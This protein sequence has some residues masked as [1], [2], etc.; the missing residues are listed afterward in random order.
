MIL[1]YIL[2]VIGFFFIIKGADL[3]VEGASSIAK[4]F[5]VSAL[6]IGLTVVAFGTSMPEFVVNVIA[7]LNGSGGIAIGNIIGSNLFNLLLIL[8][9]TA[10]VHH[11][12]VH[13][14]TV[15]KEIPFSF[16][17][18]LIL[19]VAVHD[20]VIDNLQTSVF[21]RS[22]AIMML[23]FF[24]IFLYYAYEM[25]KK[26]R[27]QVESDMFDVKQRNIWLS[28]GMI[29]V[30]IIGLFLGGKWIVDGAVVMARQLGMSEFLISATIISLG[31]SFPELVTCIVAAKK[32]KVDMAVGNIIGSNV[33]NIAYVLGASALIKP[34]AVPGNISIDIIYLLFATFLL[35]AFMF[36]GK[37]KKQLDVY[38]GVIFVVMYLIYLVF[39]LWRGGV[40]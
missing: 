35:F 12:D 2:F 26:T 37:K 14:S 5:K 23:A 31:T 22:D 40:F 1:T 16:L 4:R 8:G 7:A 13:H 18:T 6:V 27:L 3:L 38:Q 25:V 32:N 19:F 10:L 21:S 29:V 15:W 11:I 17:A 39:I 30:G 34:I 36:V 20:K 24:F 9:V 33:F 28:I